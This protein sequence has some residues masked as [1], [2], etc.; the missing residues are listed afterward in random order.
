MRR[1]PIFI[2]ALSCSG[3]AFSQSNSTFVL[4][5]IV[6]AKE[7]DLKV[8]M[9][10]GSTGSTAFTAGKSLKPLIESITPLVESD[11]IKALDVFNMLTHSSRFAT[12]LTYAVSSKAELINKLT[13]YAVEVRYPASYF[14]KLEGAAGVFMALDGATELAA[15]LSKEQ[16]DNEKLI[17]ASLNIALGGLQLASVVTD[18]VL[19]GGSIIITAAPIAVSLLVKQTPKVYKY[20]FAS[21][22]KADDWDAIS[23]ADFKDLSTYTYVECKKGDHRYWGKFLDET[24]QRGVVSSMLGHDSKWEHKVA[25]FKLRG[26]W[27]AGQTGA[28]SAFATQ[29][30]LKAVLNA[31]KLPLLINEGKVTSG[32]VTEVRKLLKAEPGDG[33]TFAA[34]DFGIIGKPH[35]IVFVQQIAGKKLKALE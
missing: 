30:S 27:L 9:A 23:S 26:T 21:E 16:K 31:C 10:S 7:L 3:T 24:A 15:E 19:P 8:V 4:H 22:L 32:R 5:A 28:A 20:Y 34:R 33:I 35:P 13:Y 6:A 25:D 1:I 17:L 12:N 18:F 29:N 11:K 14:K 2:L